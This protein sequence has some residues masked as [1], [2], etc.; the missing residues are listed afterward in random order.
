MA[1]LRSFSIV[2]DSNVKRNMVSS[3]TS[4]RPPM[5]DAQVLLC[6][7]M[8]LLSTSQEKIRSDSDACVLA[9]LTN[10]LTGSLG[11]APDLPVLSRVEGIF[12]SYFEKVVSFCHIHPTLFVFLCS[13]MYRTSPIWYRDSLPAILSK[14]S[15]MFRQLDRPHNLCLLPGFTRVQLESDGVH[16]TPFSGMEYV[17]HLFNSAQEVRRQ[18]ELPPEARV[19]RVEDR[20]VAVEDRVHYLEQ[21]HSRLHRRFELQSAANAES[22]D[23]Q[24][25]VRNESFLMIQGLPRLPKM[26]PKAWHER[27]LADS[28]KIITDLGFEPVAKYVQNMTGRGQDARV[29]YKVKVSSPEVSRS[30]RDKF[31]SFFAGGKDSRPEHLSAISVRNCV[32]PATL[33][34]VA[35]MQLLGKRYRESN[36]GAKFQVISYEPRPIL[37]LTPPPGASDRRVLTFNFIEAVSKLPTNFTKSEVEGLLRRISPSLHGSLQS[38]FVV[39]TDDMLQPREK[40]K[41]KKSKQSS[42]SQPAQS[43]MSGSESSG[44]GSGFKTPEVSR[45]RGAD[46]R[47]K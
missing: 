29:L 33:G 40:P 32:T 37:K 14:F 12:K 23:H 30:I 31:S 3:T 35:I 21:D 2:G 1:Q 11:N 22:L 15:D 19:L 47:V 46:R 20:C 42:S 17:L 45:K 43:P 34:R 27:A 8:S 41:T 44:S 25:N 39:L 5:A 10:F 38:L 4:G 18:L 24:E 26:D 6:G 7:R 16:L 9:C 13:P 36:V 28:N